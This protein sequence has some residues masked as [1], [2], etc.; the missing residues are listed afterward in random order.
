MTTTAPAR[1]SRTAHF[2]RLLCLRRW[3]LIAL[4]ATIVGSF[5]VNAT[6]AGLVSNPH[7]FGDELFYSGAASSLAH[8]QGALVRGH[9]YGFGILYPAVLSL[10]VRAASDFV[11]AYAL[12]KIA[13][14]L[15]FALAAV[16]VYFLA[17]RLLRPWPATL[18]AALSVALPSGLYAGSVLTE[19]LGYLLA[20]TSLLAIVLAI[21]WP[22]VGRQL[23]VFASV[24][25]ADLAR[26][27]FAALAI[28][29]LVAI[30]L[31]SAFGQ[32]GDDRRLRGVL[33]WWPTLACVSIVAVVYVVLLVTSGSSPAG[34]L[35]AYHVLWR[36]YGL[37]A[38][39]RW[40]LY[41]LA[42]LA[43]YLAFVP[44]VA[45]PIALAALAARGRAGFAAS[46]SYV[47][48]FLAANTIGILIV[49]AFASSPFGLDT[50][51]DRYTFYLLPLWL[52]L[53][54]Y[55]LQ[56]RM[57]RPQLPTAVGVG[58]A[59][60]LAA[61]FP[62]GRVAVRDN[63]FEDVGIA[64]WG[65]LRGW[66]T[67]LHA[68]G[69]SGERPFALFVVATIAFAVLVPRRFRWLLLVPLL[70]VFVANGAIAWKGTI[71]RGRRPILSGGYEGGRLWVD[72]AVPAG[73]PVVLLIVGNANCFAARKA[74]GLTEFFNRS[75]RTVV[76]VSHSI[77]ELPAHRVRVLG[78][79]TLLQASGSPL[80]ASAVVAPHGIE[81][82][83]QRLATG[84]LAGLVVWRVGGAVVVH[85]RSDADL[86]ARACAPA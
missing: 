71:D 79:G 44:I 41:H 24:A 77:D 64:I 49:G 32:R 19:S 80:I 31:R 10:L 43:L 86:V 84:T 78:D 60:V 36:S 70:A 28:T 55:W 6:L 65:A 37:A 81:L 85:A 54:V 40:S 52:V 21:E 29:Y 17:R 3:S 73:T 9:P 12:F 39:L 59:L 33:R 50:V 18:A 5:A 26:P 27:Q 16:P 2:Y 69:F 47:S 35:G 7:I 46:A 30:P 1:E 62:F 20:S 82:D 23:F 74:F 8:G 61:V 4:A 76:Y 83:G 57:P 11:H 53:F 58:L 63:S 66:G 25:L 34:M 45:A 72:R 68:V 75:I 42:D 15:L 38:T 14:A 22:T 67:S 48:L 51:H 13:N 56:E